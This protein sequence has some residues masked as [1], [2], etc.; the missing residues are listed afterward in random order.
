[1]KSRTTIQISENLRK[2]L[3]ILAS[4]RDLSYEELIND[5]VSVFQELN[6]ERTIISIPNKISQKI[7]ENINNTDINSVSEYVTFILRLIYS[8]KLEQ[9]EPKEM[10][11]ELKEKLENLGYLD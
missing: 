6:K 7:K 3:R 9:K 4:K 8:H 5:M 10:E 1:M 11:K 2:D